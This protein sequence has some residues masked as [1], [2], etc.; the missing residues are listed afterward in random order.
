MLS[1]ARPKTIFVIVAFAFFIKYCIFAFMITP[2]WD[3]PDESG[4]YSYVENV[5][6]GHI[7]VLGKAKMGLDVTHSWISPKAKPGLN[8]IAQHP[9]LYYVAAAPVLKVAR[10]A[11]ADFDTQVRSVRLVSSLFGA[12]TILGIAL[13]VFEF[14]RSSTLALAAQIFVACT[15][16]FL[17]LS[18]GVSHDTLVACLATW[19][20]YWCLK[21]SRTGDF[22][23]VLYCAALVALGMVTKFTGL[24][25]AVPLYFAIAYRVW[26]T[27]SLRLDKK[28]FI[29]AATIWLVM[30]SPVCIWMAHNFVLFDHF[31][32]TAASVFRH[33]HPKVP[34]GY[35]EYMRSHPFWQSTMLN[36]IG[37]IGWNGRGLGRLSWIQV[38]GITASYFLAAI[39]FVSATALL[40]YAT[41]LRH[42]IDTRF[43]AGIAVIF[44]IYAVMTRF[45]MVLAD[46]TCEVLAAAVIATVIA[47]LPHAAKNTNTASPERWMLVTAALV[48]ATFA[49][50][51]YTF[52]WEGYRGVMRATHGRYFYPVLPLFI[53]FLV[54]PLR[55]RWLSR[56]ALVG[57]LV[58]M[59]IAD[60]FFLHDAL[61]LYEQL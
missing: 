50:I 9:P 52:L 16:M 41:S 7:P 23:H 15:P 31:L 36:Y 59:F 37:L 33:Q 56:A 35:F 58:A 21:W 18:S 20:I 4:H 42:K 25:A 2:L 12:L 60:R 57:S 39:L 46:L 1:N 49:M 10:L 40:H 14:T 5:A 13:L 53:L 45:S 51:Y 28:F 26:K 44:T 47:Q 8:W 22:K 3:I 30:F 32:P 48:S 43:L 11:G 61:R 19:S 6:A 55:H 54:W 34:I 29:Q 17:Q 38:S 27:D 24:A